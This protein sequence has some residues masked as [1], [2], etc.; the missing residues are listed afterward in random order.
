MEGKEKCGNLPQTDMLK[1]EKCGNRPQAE[2]WK[3]K[4]I[5]EIFHKL[6]C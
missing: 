5:V 6:K 1:G 3:E 2:M 4:K